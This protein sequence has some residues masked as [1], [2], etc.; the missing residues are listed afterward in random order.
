MFGRRDRT[1]TARTSATCLAALS[2][3][4]V[5]TCAL[6]VR[7]DVTLPNALVVPRDSANGEVQLYTF[8]TNQG[9]AIDWQKDAHDVP[10][11]FSPLCEFTATLLLHEAGADLGVGWYNV[12]PGAVTPPTEA[13]IYQVVAPGAPIGST[14]SGTSIRA[15]PNYK[16]GLIGFALKKPGAPP[17]HYTES[18]WNT[19][20]TS[21]ACAA[22]P[23]PWILA[24]KYLSTKTPNSYYIAFE[25]GST[26]ATG[27]S[28]DGD[29]NDDVFLF[30]G[31]QCGGAGE[32]CTVDGQKGAC[33]DGLTECD[34]AGALVCKQLVQPMDE[35]C[36]AA[37]NDCDDKFDEGDE[38][39]KVGLVC[40]RGS[41]VPKCGTEFPCFGDDTCEMG[42]C[43][44]PRCVGVTCD[45]GKACR[46]G[47][48][49]APCDGIVCPSPKI[50]RVGACVDPCEGVTCAADLVCDGGVCVQNCSC[51]GCSMGR[52]CD[53]KSGKCVDPGC[54][55]M[56]CPDGE[57][58]IAGA[59]ADPCDGAKCP[60]GQVCQAGDCVDA[61]DGNG[62]KVTTGGSGGSAGGGTTNVGGASGA[63]GAAGTA[64]DGGTG[65]A[66]GTGGSGGAHRRS[67]GGGDS[68]GCV[69]HARGEHARSV[70]WLWLPALLWLRRY[71]AR[72]RSASSW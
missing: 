55:M 22:T 25:D 36:D 8:F 46:A 60:S 26:S 41:C 56:S 66:T 2:F 54:E 64:G 32:P 48:C 28:N 67:A 59:C 5:V 52:A 49:L 39:C 9:E 47:E 4:V 53:A 33:A 17:P 12:V 63:S 31:I 65:G 43:V 58:C 57:A 45:E 29:Y 27:W 21:G 1:P 61:P 10:D 51:Q 7:A 24:V 14:V 69:V 30:T 72:R 15:D 42:K 44:N 34:A 70:A 50:C 19:Q 11:T 18:K 20:C 13:E 3:A 37:D 6:G 38:L 23:G 35:R 62:G 16:G 40:V 68:G 71:R